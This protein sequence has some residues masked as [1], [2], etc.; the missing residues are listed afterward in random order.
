MKPLLRVGQRQITATE[1]MPLLQRYKL[2]DKLVQELIIEDA[3]A[4]LD[5]SEEEQYQARAEF[6]KQHSLGTPEQLQQWLKQQNLNL[7]ILNEQL[8]RSWKLRKF[9]QQQWGEAV[10]TEFRRHPEQFDRVTYS[11]LR[12]NDPGIAQELYFRLADGEATFTDLATQYSQGPEAKSGGRVGPV[13]IT[14]PHA[15]IGQILRRSQVGQV[16]PPTNI[17]NW[18]VIIR[19]EDYFPAQLDEATRQQLLDREFQHWL[20]T[21]VNIVLEQ[22]TQPPEP[23]LPP[24]AIL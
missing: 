8:I 20:Q 13:P 15:I 9:K 11:L 23:P 24:G 2:L 1:L 19:L 5:C 14:Y 10:E 4:P 3:I 17:E 12:T 18:F 6:C 22:Q 7:E 21:Q 16:W